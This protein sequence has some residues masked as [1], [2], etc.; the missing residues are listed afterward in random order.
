MC[1]LY[2]LGISWGYVWVFQAASYF[3][4][5]VARTA[6]DKHMQVFA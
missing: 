5:I 3:L 6:L 1:I 4:V 2:S